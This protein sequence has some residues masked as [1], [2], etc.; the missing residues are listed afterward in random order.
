MPLKN[1]IVTVILS[2]FPILA[3]GESLSKQRQIEIYD[4]LVGL[5]ELEK[6][7]QDKKL[8]HQ[9]SQKLRQI[10]QK[11]QFTQE[12]FSRLVNQMFQSVGI[13]GQS[14][15]LKDE[16]AFLQAH[17]KSSPFPKGFIPVARG[18][19]DYVAHSLS[20]S[21]PLKRGDRIQDLVVDK[22]QISTSAKSDPLSRANDLKYNL[23]RNPFRVS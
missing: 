21:V 19:A 3:H 16:F 18:G 11:N 6:S 7:Y 15:Y 12:S 22:D 8:W 4:E 20:T 14:L 9:N 13:P 2:F 5:V 10:F 1:L 17:Q 23:S